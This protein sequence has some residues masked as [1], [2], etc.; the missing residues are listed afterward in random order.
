MT[1]KKSR[2]GRPSRTGPELKAE[3]AAWREEFAAI[4]PARLVLRRRERGEHGD[5]PPLRPR[6]ERRCGSTAR[7]RTATGR[8]VT[9]TAAVRLGGVGGCLAFDGATNAVRFEAYV[10]RVPG[11]DAAAG[12]HRGDGQP[13]VPQDG[14]RSSG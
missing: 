9:L 13:V 11:P 14:R 8:S 6:P 4:D 7:C 10:E 3:R 12:R 2:G 1:R 5:G